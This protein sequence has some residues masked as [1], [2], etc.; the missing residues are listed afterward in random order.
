MTTARSSLSI[1]LMS[2]QAGERTAWVHL[3]PAGTSNGIDGRGPY[4]LNDAGKVITATRNHFGRTQIVVDYEH[5]T[6][7]REKNGKPAPAAGWIVG[8]ET[9][10]NGIWGLVEWTETAAAHIAK[11]EY[12][13]ISPVFYH[14]PDGTVTMLKNASLTNTP[15][16]D[17]LVALNSAEEPMDNTELAGKV[18]E[19]AALLGLPETSEQA[20]VITRL[21]QVMQLAAG[22]ADLTGDTAI[23]ANSASPDPAKFVPIGDFQRTVAELNKLRSGVTKDRAELHVS[24]HIRAGIILPY[25]KDWAVS[26]CTTN[27]KAYD[28]FVSGV[29]PGFSKLLAASGATAAAPGSVSLHS[30]SA[31][32]S[33]TELAVCRNM[34]LTTEQFNSTRT[35]SAKNME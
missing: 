27:M 17:Q 35:T 31:N 5:Q 21:K 12:R 20:V 8:L 28:D 14:Q 6:E 33:E 24:E 7:R 30:A 15:N 1:V 9:R 13:Y 23:A 22:L 34:G 2:E 3:I 29:G 11:R 16:L 4:V 25:M 10:E 19:A 26:L 32:L 18:R